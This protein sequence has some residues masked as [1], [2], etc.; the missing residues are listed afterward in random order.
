MNDSNCLDEQT[1]QR[2]MEGL[3]WCMENMEESR[4]FIDPVDLNM[5]PDYCLVV[6]LPMNLSTIKARLESSFYRWSRTHAS[7]LLLSIL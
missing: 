3:E 1:T 6:P 2:I 7:I 5:Y 4:A